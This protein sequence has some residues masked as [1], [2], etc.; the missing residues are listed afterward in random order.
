[1]QTFTVKHEWTGAVDVEAMD[2]R[3]ACEEWARRQVADDP[4]NAQ[5][6]LDEGVDLEVAGHGTYHLSAEPDLLFYAHQVEVAA[7]G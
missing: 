3:G 7:D 6:L 1:M 5:I 2:V 4:G